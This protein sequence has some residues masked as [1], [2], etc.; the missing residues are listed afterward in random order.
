VCLLLLWLTILVFLL[1][2]HQNV[3]RKL[4]EIRPAD[5][6]DTLDMASPPLGHYVTVNPRC[7]TDLAI[8][9]G[10]TDCSYNPG[11]C[12]PGEGRGWYVVGCCQLDVV[13]RQ[14][15][16]EWWHRDV[17]TKSAHSGGDSIGATWRH[18]W[19]WQWLWSVVETAS[20][21]VGCYTP[22]GNKV[23]NLYNNDFIN[24]FSH[25][26]KHIQCLA[27]SE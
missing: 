16:R 24:Q 7:S 17:N 22:R 27:K 11:R 6:L 18:H 25:T 14:W 4:L 3:S 12:L 2:F 5:L 13:V 23:L 19:R 20:Q 9:G 1:N 26:R 21:H 10:C 8:S 15:H